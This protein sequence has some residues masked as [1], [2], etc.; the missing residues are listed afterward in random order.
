MPTSPMAPPRKL[1][2]V[3]RLSALGWRAK[4]PL[5]EGLKSTVDEFI[6]GLRQGEE[7]RL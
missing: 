6:N 5:H 3:S 2:D 4:I 1:L 7:V